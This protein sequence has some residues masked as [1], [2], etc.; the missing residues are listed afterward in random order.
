MQMD[1]LIEHMRKNEKIII[2]QSGEKER[3]K[4]EGKS[5]LEYE[6]KENIQWQKKKRKL[7]NETNCG[8]KMEWRKMPKLQECFTLICRHAGE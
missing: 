7:E 6:R 2:T 8:K 4:G 3:K 1:A 5:E